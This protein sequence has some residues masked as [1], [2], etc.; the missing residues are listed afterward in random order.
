MV[1]SR[2]RRGRSAGRAQPAEREIRSIGH[3]GIRDLL[4]RVQAHFQP[5]VDTESGRIIGAEALVRAPQADRA[6]MSASELVAAAEQA[7]L[8]R[9]LTRRMLDLALEQLA[10]WR[11]AGHDV[12]VAVNTSAADLLDAGFPGEVAASLARYRVPPHAL[13]IEITETSILS[14]PERIAVVVE[15][16]RDLGVGLALDDFGTGFSSLAHLRT[17]AVEQI[18]IDRSF[19]G[20]MCEERVDFAI[21]AATIDLAHDLGLEVVAEG[22]EDEGTRRA[23]AE[24]GCD[25]IQGNL[26]APALDP[27]Q[28]RRL[29]S[30]GASRST[31]LSYGRQ[32]V[33]IRALAA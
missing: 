16:L 11:H 6:A 10:G 7:G 20:A 9:V 23:L 22:V 3:A 26:I 1:P 27:V 13:Q 4:G 17:F 2:F 18:K 32:F 21:V 14:E 19:V 24:L 29:L 33:E 30:A 5:I 15:E 31:R 25:R 8:A 12:S 28:F